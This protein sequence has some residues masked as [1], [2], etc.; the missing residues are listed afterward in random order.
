MA[1]ARPTRRPVQPPAP[2]PAPGREPRAGRAGGAAPPPPPGPPSASGRLVMYSTRHCPAC[3][4]ARR[5][6]KA[7]KAPFLER[8]VERDPTA[9]R[10]M[11]QAARR[12]GV[13]SSGVP[14]FVYR[15]Q[16]VAGFHKQRLLALLRGT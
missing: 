15:G 13:R 8:D 16:V 10:D 14:L 3:K 12:A 9:A 2:G 6:L 1:G 5:F 4:Q 11:Q 7:I